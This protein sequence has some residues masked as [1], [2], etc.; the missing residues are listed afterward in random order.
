MKRHQLAILI[1]VFTLIIA[2]GCAAS[3]PDPTKVATDLT[4]TE[5]PAP[6][7]RRPEA[8]ATD[9]P[10]ATPSITP[11]PT[12]TSTPTATP[13]PT[14]PLMIEVMRNELYLGSDIVFEETL[15]HGVNY[16][17]YIVSY[18]SEGN[19]IYAYMTVPF[20]EK[21]ETGWPVIIFNHGYIPPEIYRS[22]E[23]YVAYTH[24]FAAAEYIVFRSDYRGH[25]F[26]EGQATGGYSTPA[27]TID[28]L[29]AVGSIKKYPDADPDRIGMW[30]HSMGGHITLRSMVV[31]PDIKAGVVWGGVV[32]SYPDLIEHWW[33]PRDQNRPT[34]TPDPARPWRGSW[35][36]EMGDTYGTP[37]E[38]LDFWD[39]ISP[40][41]YIHEI[42]GPVQVH[43][44]G[45]DKSVPPILSEIFYDELVAAG[46]PTELFIYDG[47]DHDITANFSWAMY[48]SLEFFNQHVK[49]R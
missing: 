44:G 21:P 13:T 18:Q 10:S 12:N 49:N 23:R 36:Q 28:V 47:D 3:Q 29:N 37:E 11:S 38:N 7:D 1:A 4:A 25:G 16:G 45:A 20:G 33:F 40:N 26:S 27:Y 8:S 6:T 43:H 42:S 9:A 17:R 48:Y 31:S 19:K 5:R 34:R 30:G 32:A 15:S 46:V 41:S 35:R 2:V 14:H 39:A 22:T 24:G